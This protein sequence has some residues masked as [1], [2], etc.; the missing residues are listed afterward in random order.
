M[1]QSLKILKPDRAKPKRPSKPI[2]IKR[3]LSFGV[4]E[5]LTGSRLQRMK[6]LLGKST[7]LD[8]ESRR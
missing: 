6:A 8:K 5:Q 1:N 4:D 3:C 7:M 2:K